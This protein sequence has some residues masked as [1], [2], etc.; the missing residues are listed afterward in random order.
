MQLELSKSLKSS[1]MQRDNKSLKCRTEGFFFEGSNTMSILRHSGSCE[2]EKVYT[3]YRNE[4]ERG[5][6]PVSLGVENQRWNEQM[7]TRLSK[8][9]ILP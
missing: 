2:Q 7:V 9:Q 5:K 3:T 1:V 6:N 4:E 8:K